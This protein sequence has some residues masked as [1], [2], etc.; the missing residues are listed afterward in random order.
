MSIIYAVPMIDKQKAAIT[1]HCF[2]DCGKVNLG[3]IMIPQVGGCWPCHEADCPYE[4]EHSEV[5]GKDQITGD[6]VCIRVLL[7]EQQ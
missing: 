5:L 6:D 2:G 4:K 7:P 3:A 1:A